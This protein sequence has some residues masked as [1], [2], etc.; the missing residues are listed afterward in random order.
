VGHAFET[1]C[2]SGS[3]TILIMP[4]GKSFMG[5]YPHAQKCDYMGVVPGDRMATVP[6]VRDLRQAANSLRRIVELTKGLPKETPKDL[7]LQDRL[8]LAAR[9][10]DASVDSH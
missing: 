10:L 8:E 1:R 5:S 7:V 9:V 4:S 3:D 6:R 2:S